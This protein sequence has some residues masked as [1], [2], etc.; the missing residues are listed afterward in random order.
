MFLVGVIAV[1]VGAIRQEIVNSGVQPWG[2]TVVCAACV[3]GLALV[4]LHF[5]AATFVLLR[6]RG[7][8]ALSPCGLLVRG[9][10]HSLWGGRP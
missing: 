4:Y 9:V 1:G 2:R 6:V 8:V 3:L 10:M 5:S 7:V